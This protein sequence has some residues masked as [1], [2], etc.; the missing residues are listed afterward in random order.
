MLVA[1]LVVG[2][3][4]GCVGIGGVLLTP[5][6]VYV[7]GLDFHLAAATSMWAFLFAGAAGTSIYSRH[8][9]IDWRLAAW[10][11][12]GVVP[13]AFAGAGA[14]TVLPEG[15]L[16][17]LLAGLMVLT[18]ADAL[19]RGPVV[20]QEARRFGATTL[21]AVG[22]LV[23][24][25]SALTGTGGAVLLVPILL[26]LRAPVLASVGAAQAVALPVVIFSTV[27]YVL[28]GSVDFV[29]G[30]AGGLVAAVG[31]VFGAR[32]AHAV[33]A[34]VLRRVVATA[35]LCAGLLIAA[36]TVW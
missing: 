7:G 18:G 21:L 1:A 15:L 19:M 4:I 17:A 31:V 29:L 27:G 30:T 23:G 25:G 34:A 14:N 3:L 35:L 33:P 8:G 24:F 11:G 28:Y 10:L 2:L 12:V 6:L 9:S 32:I 16:M 22:A 20:E 5:A 26:L 13:A 36:Q